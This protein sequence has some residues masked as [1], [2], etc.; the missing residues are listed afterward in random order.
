M[1]NIECIITGKNLGW[2][3]ANNIGIK[4]VKTKYA[5]DFKSRY[6]FRK[7]AIKNF[8]NHQKI[9]IFWLMGPRQIDHNYKIEIINKK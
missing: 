5:Y 8:L 9:K 4:K 6:N 2:E 3:Q 7:N 1:T